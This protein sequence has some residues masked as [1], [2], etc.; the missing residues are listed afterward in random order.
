MNSPIQ[1]YDVG[2]GD[3]LICDLYEV[4]CSVEK[5]FRAIFGKYFNDKRV[6]ICHLDSGDPWCNRGANR[7]HLVSSG[8]SYSQYVYQFAHEYCHYQLPFSPVQELRWLEESICELASLY[9]LRQVDEQWEAEPPYPHWQNYHSNFTKYAEDTEKNCEIINL[10]FSV[11]PN[12]NLSYLRREE[13]D[14]PKNRYIALK[15]LPLFYRRPEL[16]HSVPFLCR[17]NERRTFQLALEEW[18]QVSPAESRAALA[19]LALIFSI[20]L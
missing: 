4:L 16:W 14:R 17:V 1:I 12:E 5:C 20:E 15:L 3:V 18:Q 7:I 2:W 11:E 8:K 19:E 10:D 13:Y 6:L 9:T